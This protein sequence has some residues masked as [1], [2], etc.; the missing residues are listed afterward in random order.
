MGE[1]GVRLVLRRPRRRG[2]QAQGHD[3]PPD[4]G[5]PEGA[6]PPERVGR[7][8]HPARGAGGLRLRRGARARTR[9]RQAGR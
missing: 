4:P 9:D 5:P 8:R 2:P 7:R 1:R 3:R 6:D